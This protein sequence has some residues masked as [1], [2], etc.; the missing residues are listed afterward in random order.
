MQ[1]ETRLAI[2]L[3]LPQDMR[4]GVEQVKDATTL[5]FAALKLQIRHEK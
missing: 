4:R 1:A 5:Y 2:P 3:L